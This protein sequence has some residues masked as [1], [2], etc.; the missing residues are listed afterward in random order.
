MRVERIR[1]IECECV[2]V[3]GIVTIHLPF[4]SNRLWHVSI[5]NTK[6]H[7]FSQ[8]QNIFNGPSSDGRANHQDVCNVNSLIAHYSFLI[9]S[10]ET[11]MKNL[12]CQL[13]THTHTYWIWM[14][15]LLWYK[16]FN[17][18]V[19]TIVMVIFILPYRSNV[20]KKSRWIYSF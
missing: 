7:F 11:K 20:Q 12:R 16:I 5:I 4:D 19:N 18:A 15:K 10:A 2:C 6:I 8:T 17:F 9:Y 13:N 14:S 1:K 3:C